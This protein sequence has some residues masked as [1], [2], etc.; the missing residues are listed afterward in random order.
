M[1]IGRC[2]GAAATSKLISTGSPLA[3]GRRT[4]FQRRA[5][6]AA[7]ALAHATAGRLGKAHEL[8]LESGNRAGAAFNVGMMYL[9]LRNYRLA[10]HWFGIAGDLRPAFAAAQN[11]RRQA[12]RLAA[13]TANAYEHTNRTYDNSNRP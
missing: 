9:A 12:A 10:E 1:R 8:L 2:T 13:A 3:V 6:G 4:S 7:C 5:F 11:R